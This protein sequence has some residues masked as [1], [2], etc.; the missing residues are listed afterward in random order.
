[1]VKKSICLAFE[2]HQPFRLKK[3]F[4]WTKQMF[5]RGLKST[6]LFDYYFSEADNREVF[7]KVARKCYCPTNELIRRL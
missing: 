3:D 6:D 7:E 4:F 2:V 5:R 1:M